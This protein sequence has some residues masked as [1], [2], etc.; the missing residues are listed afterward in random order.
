MTEDNR[1][2]DLMIFWE[3]STLSFLVSIGTEAAGDRRVWFISGEKR[4]RRKRTRGKLR[5]AELKADKK[6]DHGEVGLS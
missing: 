4:W 2:D 3:F 1:G 6:A 5:K